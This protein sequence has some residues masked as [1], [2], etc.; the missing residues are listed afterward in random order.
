MGRPVRSQAGRV[1]TLLMDGITKLKN[2]PETD[3]HY[4]SPDVETTFRRWANV[5]PQRRAKQMEIWRLRKLR[6]GK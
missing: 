3:R 4:G 5:H 6:K 1:D 2:R